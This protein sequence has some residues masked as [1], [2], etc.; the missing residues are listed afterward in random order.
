M[1]TEK[2]CK[3][4]KNIKALSEF[5]PS[6]RGI[7]GVRAECKNCCAEKARDYRAIHIPTY[8]RSE[9]RK[10]YE[11]NWYQGNRD[12][13]LQMQKLKDESPI[14]KYQ[15]LKANAKKRGKEFF[16]L[17]EDFINWY[18][19]QLRYCHY[20]EAPE[21]I[22][23]EWVRG[24]SRPFLT[25]DRKDNNVGYV[26]DNIVLCCGMCNTIKGSVFTYYEMMDIAKTHLRP[27]LSDFLEVKEMLTTNEKR[28]ES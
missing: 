15:K 22:L 17:Q 8:S 5:S 7:G 20:C 10:E 13:I 25:V 9:A 28:G 6:H 16:L 14:R 4:C 11:R 18:G 2:L 26:I 23:A 12:K 27:K 1:I 19:D 24:F 3:K 21:E